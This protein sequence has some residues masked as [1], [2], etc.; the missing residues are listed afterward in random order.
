MI[1]LFFIIVVNLLLSSNLFALFL[2]TDPPEK[3]TK[4]YIRK[5]DGGI[6]TKI[7]YRGVMCF[8]A[9]PI[10]RRHFSYIVVANIKTNSSDWHRY[11]TKQKVIY[12][13]VN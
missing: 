1:K 13:L 2:V 7:C 5:I 4:K 3:I 9:D 10:T 12:K 6:R 11:Q 8:D